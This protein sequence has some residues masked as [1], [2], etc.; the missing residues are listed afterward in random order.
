[1]SYTEYWARYE[2]RNNCN[3]KCDGLVRTLWHI[4]QIVMETWRTKYISDIWKEN[5]TTTTTMMIV[6]M[7]IISYGKIVDDFT[8]S[9]QIR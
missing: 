6:I 5:T 7:I 3:E 2:C 1:M 8:E 9:N 4:E